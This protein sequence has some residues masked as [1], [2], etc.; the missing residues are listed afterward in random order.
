MKLLWI[1]PNEPLPA[2]QRALKDPPG[3]LAAGS[4]LSPERLLEAYQ[5]GIFPWYS[6]GQPVL[7]WSPDP[8]MVLFPSE[9]RQSRSLQQTMRRAHQRQHWRIT[10]DLAFE[11]VI[12]ACATRRSHS[13]E[14]DNGT[15]ITEAII[16]AYVGLHRRGIA[17]SVEIWAS[18]GTRP[19]QPDQA[20]LVGGLYGVAL[21][22]AFF[23]E[24]MFTRETDASKAALAALVQ[25]LR[26]WQFGLIDCQ[27]QTAHLASMGARPIPREQFLRLLVEATTAPAPNWSAARLQLH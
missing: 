5:Q 10:H 21:G 6:A 20:Q 1:E 12:R 26:A 19:L 24:S 13:A 27:Q 8:R 25:Q 14:P 3:L 23:G 2:P 11:A 16:Q 15:W 4:D 17:H 7:W 18:P 9:F 22:R